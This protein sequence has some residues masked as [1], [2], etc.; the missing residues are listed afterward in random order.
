MLSPKKSSELFLCSDL[1]I[2]AKIFMLQGK[3]KVCLSFFLNY[4]RK[5]IKKG[6]Y[7]TEFNTVVIR[8]RSD[9]QT[10]HFYLFYRQSL[11]T[12]RI[13]RTC[14][15]A[16]CTRPRWEVQLMFGPSIWRQKK[17][18]PNGWWEALHFYSLCKQVKKLLAPNALMMTTNGSEKWIT[19][20]P[21]NRQKLKEVATFFCRLQPPFNNFF[22]FLFC[23]F[24]CI[25][26]SLLF[27]FLVP[28]LGDSNSLLP[29][30]VGFYIKEF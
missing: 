12:S 6:S 23:V 13:W 2:P 26:L 15:P 11:W 16:Q 17:S 14:I 20:L 9:K 10:Q 27:L 29:E 7:L 1:K 19:N 8:M 24:V 25:R 4:D 3:I 18:L 28:C 30:S 5:W 21:C 22:I